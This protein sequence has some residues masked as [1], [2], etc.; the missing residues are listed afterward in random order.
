MQQYPL[1]LNEGEDK[2]FEFTL[3]QPTGGLLPL[4][5][6]TFKAQ[7]RDSSNQL[8]L[9]LTPEVIDAPNGKLHLKAIGSESIGKTGRH[10]W[11]LRISGSF[12]DSY[13]TPSPFV[14]RRTVTR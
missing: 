11:D 2:T 6:L 9:S 12:G 13:L 1:E 7:V 5:G 8:V 4:T 14:I 10:T 3:S